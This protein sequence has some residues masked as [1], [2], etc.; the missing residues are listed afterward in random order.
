MFNFEVSPRL[1]TLRLFG[2]DTKWESVS[3][4]I[5]RRS[6]NNS[7]YLAA[8]R[9]PESPG[10]KSMSGRIIAREFAGWFYCN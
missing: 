3:N 7:I 9:F 4:A 8:S 1:G 5:K 2:C 10:A 6:R